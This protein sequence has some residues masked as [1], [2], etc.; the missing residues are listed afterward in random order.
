M[1]AG[2]LRPLLTSSR[3]KGVVRIMRE[4]AAADADNR[5]LAISLTTLARVA[6]LKRFLSFLSSMP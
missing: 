6:S 1:F 2:F 5:G 3:I 4:T